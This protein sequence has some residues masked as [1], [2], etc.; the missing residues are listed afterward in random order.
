[1]TRAPIVRAGEDDR[2]GGDDR[3]VADRRRLRAAR[4]WRSSAATASAACRRR[5]PRAP[6]RPR[7]GRCP[8]RRSRCGWISAHGG[9]SVSRSSARTTMAP[10]S[11]IF[12]LS[13]SPRDQ[14]EEGLALEPQRLRRCRSSGCGCRRSASA[15]RRSPPS[16]CHGPF[17]Y[18]VTFRSSSMSSNTT[19]FS[20][21]DDGHPPHLV[22]VEPREVHVRDLAGGEAEVA[23]DDVLDA[24][25]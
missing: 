4:A 5:R 20:L 2:A 11:A 8:R 22:R 15:T 19:I 1:M 12:R 10:S 18:T 16:C 24:R 9:D 6:S 17:S 7:R 3:A 25:R 21:P 13:P 14:L 23:E